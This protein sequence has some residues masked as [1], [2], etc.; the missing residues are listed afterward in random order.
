MKIIYFFIGFYF[1]RYYVDIEL[2]E[3][4]INSSLIDEDDGFMG[5]GKLEVEELE[6]YFLLFNEMILEVWMYCMVFFRLRSCRLK[7]I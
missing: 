1:I 5:L 4:S 2:G 3:V 6:R 7:L